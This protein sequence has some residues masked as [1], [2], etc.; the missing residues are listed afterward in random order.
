MQ[1]YSTM[2]AAVLLWLL[3]SLTGAWADNGSAS[4]NGPPTFASQDGATL[5]RTICQGCHM[6]D[7]KG[8]TG[9][10]TYP[11]LAHDP[12]LAAAAYPVYTIIQGRNSMPS[13]AAYLSDAQ[14]AAVVNYVRTH[15]GNDYRDA[16]SAALA[17]TA[18]ATLLRDRN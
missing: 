11:N 14:V 8:A 9:A 13:F 4:M 5:Y 12:T 15:F 16:V 6:S 3:A 2:L 1:F 17:G 7:A 10:A 18:R